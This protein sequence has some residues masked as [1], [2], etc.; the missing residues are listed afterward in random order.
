MSTVNPLVLKDSNQKIA[1]IINDLSDILYRE[2]YQL[3]YDL[4]I[5]LKFP[6]SADQ[7]D[8]FL[9]NL[10]NLLLEQFKKLSRSGDL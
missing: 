6:T 7:E 10:Y 3:Y 4:V 8:I 9:G 1:R 2:D 5:N